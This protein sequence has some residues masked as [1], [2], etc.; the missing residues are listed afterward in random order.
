MYLHIQ[1]KPDGNHYLTIAEKYHVPG[2]GSREKTIETIG[3]LNDYREKYDD[4]IA[5]FRLRAKELTEKL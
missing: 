1:K 3:Y 2:V 5:F 4:P